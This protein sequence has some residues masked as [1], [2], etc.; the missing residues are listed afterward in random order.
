VSVE[1][2]DHM[3]CDVAFKYLV[4]SVYDNYSL[5]ETRAKS[6]VYS[7]LQ[8]DVINFV[9]TIIITTN[10]KGILIKTHSKLIKK[11]NFLCLENFSIKGKFDYHKEDLDWTIELFIATKMTIV[12]PFNP[13]IKLVFHPK[14]TIN[15]FGKCMLQPF[16]TTTIAFIVIGVHGEIDGK[17]EMFVANGTSP[18]TFRL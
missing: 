18:K 12:P 4:L 8:V 17:F 10:V 11:G 5:T 7:Y 1:D 14:D 9:G 6:V 2:I 15:N 13:P 16:T 3:I